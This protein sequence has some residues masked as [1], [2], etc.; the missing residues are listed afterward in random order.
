MTSL[1]A[2]TKTKLK[3]Y[4]GAPIVVDNI[5]RSGL[6]VDP[7]RQNEEAA[8]G[9]RK[10]IE[11]AGKDERV[12]GVVIQMVDERSWDGQLVAVVK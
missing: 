11:K 12:M 8:W 5:V 6:L 9:P 4:Q 2:S 10:V 7:A 3:C 1:Y